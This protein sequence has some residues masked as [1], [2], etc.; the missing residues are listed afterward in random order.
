MTNQPV[1]IKL[2][3]YKRDADE[4]TGNP[5]DAPA[6]YGDGI[7]TDAEFQ[8][9]AAENVLDRQG[10]V[11]HAKGD[12]VA[13]SVKTAGTDASVTTDALWPGLYEIVELMPPTGYQPADGSILVDARD[14]A[15]QSE[16]AIITYE[17]VITN[18]ITYG[19]QAIVKILG[20]GTAE[21]DP[22]RVETPEPAAEFK[23]YL[24]KAGSYENAREFERDYL[25]TDEN[26]YAMTKPLPFGI[27]VLEQVKGKAGY[28]I[29]GPI[30]FEIDGTESLVN[31]PP[32]PLSDQPILY[33]LKFIKTDSESGKVITLSNA[34]FRL[35]DASGEYV[36]QTVFYPREQEIDTFTTD[37][38]GSVTLPETVTWG[39]Y[40][41]E[42]MKAP[43]G[44]LIR[45]EDFSV[46]VGSEGDQPGET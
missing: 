44:Y 41:V 10:N 39:L 1:Q 15:Q 36:K 30:T 4:Y 11:V 13:A 21:A 17:G 45:S 33:R 23:V 46:F 14:A 31:P 12:V 37:E 24:K 7:L 3:L 43:E 27:Y 2:K 32:L 8:V 5:A 20:D 34:T 35:M 18:E 26:G 28:E 6:V 38:T 9:L 29:K 22:P 40:F 42:E 25:T 16:E 19:A